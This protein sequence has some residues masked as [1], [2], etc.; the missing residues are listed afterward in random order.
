MGQYFLHMVF[1]KKCYHYND[2]DALQR[3]KVRSSDGDTVFLNIVTG[4]LQGDIINIISIHNISRLCTK[5]VNRS[6]KKIVSHFKTTTNRGY[7]HLV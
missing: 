3:Y 2:N 6:N 7:P 5:N 4:V 1:Q